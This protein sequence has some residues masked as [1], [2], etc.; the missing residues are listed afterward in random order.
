MSGLYM[1]YPTERVSVF[2]ER[3]WRSIKYE[4]V[5]LHDYATGLDLA[6]GMTHG[7]NF[8]NYERPHQSLDYAMPA[9]VHFQEE[10]RLNK[11]ALG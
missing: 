4:Y 8:Y 10:V 6:R 1:V 5:Y 7:F 2:C 11:G 3:L 9:A